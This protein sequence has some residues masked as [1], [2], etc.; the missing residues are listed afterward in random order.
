M[1]LW[2]T[3][4]GGGEP[5]LFCVVVGPRGSWYQVRVPCVNMSCLGA[6]WCPKP[7][8]AIKTCRRW[9]QSG[10]NGNRAAGP[11]RQVAFSTS[12]DS[13]T[14]LRG[15]RSGQL[16]CLRAFTPYVRVPD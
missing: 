1:G 6:E 9:V 5:A 8:N 16:T 11:P 3:P 15:G 10:A 13:P 12:S 2:A 14:G 7:A 4:A